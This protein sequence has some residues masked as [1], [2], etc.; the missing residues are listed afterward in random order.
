MVRWRMV[1]LKDSSTL[2][3][4]TGMTNLWKK[5]N[6]KD[7]SPVIVLNAPPGTVDQLEPQRIIHKIGRIKRIEFL[8]A[9]V[10]KRAEIKRIAQHL[11][12]KMQGDEVVWFAYPKQTSKNY[13]CN[14]NRDS[15][16]ESVQEA[17]FEGVRQ[18]AIDDDWSAIRF[19]RTKFIKSRSAG[20][21]SRSAA[22][23]RPS[24]ELKKLRKICLKLPDTKETL[25]WDKPHFRV[26]DKIFAGLGEDN[27]NSVMGC[28][29]E[30]MHAREIVK[31]PG[32][33]PAPYVGHKGWVSIDLSIVKDWDLVE[34]MVLESYRLIAPKR[35]LKKLSD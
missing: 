27:G 24:N 26:A 33:S 13:T 8:L 4:N 29:L 30:S 19:R 2:S 25:T 34:E 18:V 5:L 20:T 7:Q 9:F 11:S 17:G 10:T 14:F 21:K 31:T 6:L 16:W 23:P 28:K 15:G 22:P 3:R 1:S 12:N 35:S 32:F